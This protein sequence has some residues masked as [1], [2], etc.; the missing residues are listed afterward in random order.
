[1]ALSA[2]RDMPPEAAPRALDHADHLIDEA[3]RSLRELSRGIYP[4]TLTS[5]GLGPAIEETADRLDLRVWL[6]VPA[7]RLPGALEKTLYFFVSEALT[8]A[9]KHAGTDRLRVVVRRDDT[10][11]VAEVHDE[12]VGGASSRGGGL[13]QL[14]DRVTA[15]GGELEI[16]SEH[17]HGTHLIARIPCV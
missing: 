6:S 15:H 8:N 1:M 13:T 4:H 12:G 14:K 10:T 16:T 9:R 3:L 5:D 2:L 11:V 7:E 17:G